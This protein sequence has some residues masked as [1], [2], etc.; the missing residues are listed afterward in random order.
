MKKVL[1]IFS[2]AML[3]FSF[4]GLASALTWDYTNDA[5]PD[6]YI[7]ND[8]KVPDSSNWYKLNLPIWYNSDYV[9]AFWIDMYGSN[10]NSS[11]TVDIWRNL[12]GAPA[13]ARKIVGYNVNNSTRPFILRLDL[14]DMDLF[15]NYLR[16]NGTWTG[17]VDT[18]IGLNNITLE[19]FDSLS[20]FLIGY[21]C[22]YTY[23]KTQIHI[24]QEIP[25]PEPG[26]LLLLGV[27]LVGLWGFRKK[28]KK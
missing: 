28:F 2:V 5:I 20:S 22:S 21:A 24:E 12:S 4:S 18:G 13:D 9:T 23:D 19:S 8:S 1:V 27:G 17:Y 15:Y 7:N 25:V 14:M 6:V 10:D 16:T 11:Y 26:T 3:L